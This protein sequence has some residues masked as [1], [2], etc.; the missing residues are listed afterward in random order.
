MEI[1]RIRE[2]LAEAKAI[3]DVSV[4]KDGT[5]PN[6]IN[7][8]WDEINREDL[9]ALIDYLEDYTSAANAAVSGTIANPMQGTQWRRTGTWRGGAIYL[10][11]V[12]RDGGRGKVLRLY[13]E[14]FYGETTV[15]TVVIENGCR[16]LVEITE[17][18]FGKTTLP[19]VPTSISGVNYQIQAFKV[20]EK[21]GTYSG[22]IEKR[23]RVVQDVPE[24]DS[25]LSAAQTGKTTEKLGTNDSTLLPI[26]QETGKIKHRAITKNDDC[27]FDIKK[28]EIAPVDQTV[29]S[30]ED[31]AAKSASRIF[32]TEN[33]T[34]LT[35]PTAAPGTIKRNENRPTESGKTQTTEEVVTVKDQTETSYEKSAAES[36]ILALHTEGT[37]LASPTLADGEIKESQ[38]LPTEAGKVRTQ[39]RTRTAINQTATSF[40]KTAL[41]EMA[42]VLNTQGAAL[43]TEVLADGT[44]VEVIQR[45]TQFQNK[46]E[47]IRRVKTGIYVYVSASY[48][49]QYGT[50]FYG[51]GVN[52]TE[53][54]YDAAVSAANL[55]A[56]TNNG[57][58]KEPAEYKGLVNFLIQKVANDN[59]LKSTFLGT[60]GT[61]TK[62]LNDRERRIDSADATGYKWRQIT[63]AVKDVWG[64]ID[65]CWNG[66]NGG[67]HDSK[68]PE[69]VGTVLGVM[70]YHAT[71]IVRSYGNWSPGATDT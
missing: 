70:Q 24:Y 39:E 68:G 50:S 40:E 34:P 8:Y 29:T 64:T 28:E 52:A 49:D 6:V 35:T 69:R 71:Q 21:R 46:Y 62:S 31:S 44:T 63:I 60:L 56:N 13:Q 32:H 5:N 25:A 57:V 19:T 66:I 61:W 27:S 16:Y 38:N 53:T 3:Q 4:N 65:A 30:A 15:G 67:D 22:Y 1:A 41:A 23:T 42:A 51:R 54:Q 2:I 14:L 45:P 10:K 26:V 43:E 17:T 7:R 58:S 59:S 9:D 11:E 20:D 55:T 36:S 18:F 48:V 47:T 12:D 33:T 37:V